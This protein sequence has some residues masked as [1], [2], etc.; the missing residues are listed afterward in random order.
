MR[1]MILGILLSLLVVTAFP[2]DLEFPLIQSLVYF[3]NFESRGL[4]QDK[5][6]L[7][8]HGAYS[9]VFAYTFDRS[10]LTDLESFT[11][12]FSLRYGGG[13]DWTAEL[14][15]RFFKVM[16]GGLDKIIEDFHEKFN[17]P[18]AGRDLYP[19]NTVNYYYHD[20]FSYTA[21]HSGF[22]P[23]QIGL[24]K[25]YPL[26]ATATLFGR[27]TLGIP[28]GKAA[29]FSSDKLSLTAGAGA[30]YRRNR[31]SAQWSGYIAW[32]KPP[33]WLAGEPFQTHLFFTEAR[34]GLDPVTIGFAIRTSPF[35]SG[36]IQSAGYLINLGVRIMKNVEIGLTE[37][38][39]PYDTSPDVG[40]YLHIV[41]K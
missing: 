34:L 16:G 12:T 41:L 24:F 39:P 26:G 4:A 2:N 25:E 1:R 35:T 31:F 19:R 18:K 30:T 23:L 28:L 21:G 13:N 17:Y 36:D 9:N 27:L 7:D 29:G 14:Q 22:S 32:F 37:D 15:L 40:F 38:L 5:W 11:N 8:W 20:R 6:A 33:S 10:T 3:P